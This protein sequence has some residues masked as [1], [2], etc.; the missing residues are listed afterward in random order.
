[1]EEGKI[2]RCAFIEVAKG[3]T[4]DFGGEKPKMV[5]YVL[6]IVPYAI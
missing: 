5:E 1:M 6:K 2:R 3:I 4:Y